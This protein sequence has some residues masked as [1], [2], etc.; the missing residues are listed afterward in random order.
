MFSPSPLL[1]AFRYAER[2]EPWYQEAIS[3]FEQVLIL[4]PCNVPSYGNIAFAYSALGKQK[5]ALKYL[6]KALLLDPTYEPA[7]HNRELIG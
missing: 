2:I 4:N 3:F 1:L 5:I 6:D 7:E